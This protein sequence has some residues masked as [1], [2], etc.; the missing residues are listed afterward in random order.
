MDAVQA[1][2]GRAGF[3]HSQGRRA[4][5]VD[6][7]MA[8]RVLSAL[9]ALAFAVPATG[10]AVGDFDGDGRDDI[11]L[12]DPES[13][14]WRYH[15]VGDA[16]PA[17]EPV[18]VVD[19]ATS[20]EADAEGRD[21]P[22]PANDVFRFMATDDF[23]G[24]GRDDALFQRRDTRAW[25]YH[26]VQ[27]TDADPRTVAH[28]DLGVTKDAA[29]ELLATGD[30]DGDGRD[31]LVL[32]D[33]ATGD[34][35]G[36]LLKA[37]GTEPRTTLVTD[38]ATDDAD[39][40]FAGLGDFNGDGRADVLLRHAEQ[41]GWVY[42]Q[43]NAEARGTQYR[44]PVTTDLVYAFEGTGD[45]N[46]DGKDDILLRNTATG[47][48][49]YYVVDGPRSS[50]RRNL[51]LPSDAAYGYAAIG[52]FDGDGDGSLLLRRSDTGAWAVY[53]LSGST[54]VAGDDAG[55]AKDLAWTPAAREP[56]NSDD[57]IWTTED[58]RIVV[59]MEPGVMSEA[60]LFD[61]DRHTLYFTPDDD[62]DY[63]R[64]VR[65]LAWEDDTGNEVPG[66]S[67][68]ALPFSFDYDGESWDAVTVS[69]GLLL[70][71][72]DITDLYWDL[73]MLAIPMARHAQNLAESGKPAI[74]P[75]YKPGLG[76]WNRTFRVRVSSREDRVVFTW[77]ATEPDFFVH[78]V[79]PSGT[80]QV[81]AVL[82]ADGDIALSYRDVKLGDGVVG[83]FRN[84]AL[85][86]GD[87]VFRVEDAENAELP[88]H[89]DLRR[90]ALYQT[91]RHGQLLLEFT[92]RGPVPDPPDGDAY[93]YRLYL[94]T[95]EPYWNVGVDEDFTWFADVRH[96]PA[97]TASFG[98]EVQ[99]RGGA[100]V[101]SV[102]IDAADVAG[103]AA[104]T[105][106]AGVHFDEEGYEQQD[107]AARTT[108]LLPAFAPPTQP[109]LSAPGS[110]GSVAHRE[111]FRYG[112]PGDLA[113]VACRI[114][115]R[116]GD[117]F[118]L[119]VFH[120]EA[121]VDTQMTSST[122]RNYGANRNVTGIGDS[123][124]A[125]PPCDASRLKGHWAQPIWVQSREVRHDNLL[126]QAW[127]FD[128]GISHFAHE[129]THV[130]LAHMSYDHDGR[131]ERLHGRWGDIFHWRFEL[132]A[133]AAFAWRTGTRTAHSIMGGRNWRD[134]GDGTYSPGSSW[135]DHVGGGHS[136][137][138]LYA[139][140]LAEAS[141]VP[142]MFILRNPRQVVGQS[143]RYTGTKE[144]LGI[145]EIVAAMGS[146]SPTVAD[147][148]TVFNAGLAY[149]L[150]HGK[151]PDP[152]LLALHGEY[153]DMVVKYWSHVTGERSEITTASEDAATDDETQSEPDA[154]LASLVLAGV[155]FGT[156][157]AETLAYTVD[158]GHAVAST[159]VAA[160]PADAAASVSITPTDADAA[161]TGHQV[162]LAVGATTIS[163]VVTATDDAATRTYTVTVNR[164]SAPVATVAAGAAVSEGAPATFTVRLDKAATA[165]LSVAVAAT[166]TAGRLAGTPPTAVTFAAG[167]RSAAVTMATLDDTV[168]RADGAVTLT[169]GA[170]TH[171]TVGSPATATVAVAEND[172]AAFSVTAAPAAV[173]EGANATLA[174]SISNGV[175]F[176]AAQEIALA[177]TGDVD[178]ADY[179][180]TPQTL[181]LAAGGTSVQ[182]VFAALDDG[183]A[184]DA[185]TA[186]VTAVL[187]G[188]TLGSATLTISDPPLPDARIEGVPQVGATLA[189]VP[190]E[191][192]G[193]AVRG[194]A[195]AGN[196][197][198]S[199]NAA[200]NATGAVSYQWLRDDADIAGATGA[201]Y[202]L[203]AADAGARVSLRATRG[204]LS[205]E[206][207]ATIPVWGP[208]GNPPLAPDEE[209]LAGTMLTVGS[210]ARD[211][212]IPLAGFL[213]FPTLAFGA[214][215]AAAF[216]DA[217]TSR[218]L[219]MLLVN[220]MGG[221]GLASAPAMASTD[222]LRV[223]WDAHRVSGF[224][225]GTA[226]GLPVWT[227]ATPQPRTEYARY[228]YGLSDGVRV[229]VSVR[230][231]HPPPS[232]TLAAVADSV[233]EGE[234]AEF[235]V[236]LS[237]APWRTFE[238]AVAVTAEGV[239]LAAAAPATATFAKGA[240]TAT[241][242]LATV[243]DA[244]VSG[245]GAV[246]VRLLPGDDYELGTDDE[247]SPGD[248][249]AT[250]TVAED[251]AAE[252]AVAADPAE[253]LGGRRGPRSRCR[254]PTA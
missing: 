178:A 248:F 252:F 22:L 48:W 145:E 150:E 105:F 253:I 75:L 193:G 162:A 201:T 186:T 246:T 112:H 126:S 181:S 241:L 147:A 131:R 208:P 114:V 183:A 205:A 149:L 120:T 53:D 62:G 1:K 20:T 40:A 185:E 99:E 117:R 70:F 65:E 240:A 229:A 14:Q 209:E 85:V 250:V 136:W 93:S 223:Y 176:A 71:G 10:D 130:W 27:A 199:S 179:T 216:D 82:H 101:V 215:D 54:A 94:D 184:E 160:T 239:E 207:P 29:F 8:R 17:D 227:A 175:T 187:D 228:Q 64:E 230:R 59:E 211:R 197:I 244:V 254:S 6:W 133:P 243:D 7:R 172:A 60:N 233:D 153:R 232:A 235:E 73:R 155:D 13:G 72:G 122:W 134:N 161:A 118:D 206:S 4:G 144:T 32:R 67:E 125:A 30:L 25:L 188:A 80:P 111:V 96:G 68:V 79:P 98:A 47:E 3:A 170:G 61:L 213:D 83:L 224:R 86:K 221:F 236:R 164:A 33:A 46:G 15:A 74:A 220:A 37:A 31:D 214:L 2:T 135:H 129:F 159:T 238:V 63:T 76:T 202:T 34:W 226:D 231:V 200:V 169:L 92:L 138:D 234:A 167:D 90:V 146:R 9:A 141:E 154:S 41:G 124:R 219:T 204:A 151:T 180:L 24:D 225:A 190:A 137:L 16:N 156:F 140:G 163:V 192:S 12:R 69:R 106:A 191:A 217:G 245:D 50:A 237:P 42:Y 100:N 166:A 242:S 44:I 78:G 35:R 89:L 107:V 196:P 57:G 39:Y 108:V 119:V 212:P 132:H 103:L 45:L 95:E 81:Q 127:R 251:D 58:G 26:A 247:A 113:H 87:L 210:S 203:T 168:V 142:D 52:D 56:P 104:S 5:G 189:A 182:A 23:D 115:G 177:V 55:L 165:P 28:G 21:L 66:R 19:D 109:D 143:T 49:I 77:S 11:L 38:L 249:E 139:M 195:D 194:G 110:G 218:E 88:A 91:N 128:A 102:L 173:E 36:Y 116:L 222:G 198:A 121:R 123:G 171:Y 152:G 84:E 51:G 148:Q 97:W 158:V 18:S 43:M 174:V 157:A